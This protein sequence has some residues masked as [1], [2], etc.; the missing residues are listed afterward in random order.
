[1]N[2]VA[3]MEG[4]LVEQIE[5]TRANSEELRVKTDQF[6]QFI[7]QFRDITKQMYDLETQVPQF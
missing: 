4:R 2:R 1:M 7:N 6:L 3:G 5:L